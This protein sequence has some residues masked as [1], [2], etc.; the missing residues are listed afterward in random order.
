MNHPTTYETYVKEKENTLGD[1]FWSVDPSVFFDRDR[2]IEFF[3]TK[4][5]STVEKLN[6]ISRFLVYL[7]ILLFIVKRNYNIFF[8]PIIGLFVIYI[9]YYND[10]SF[11]RYNVEQF[12]QKIK[13]ALGVHPEV[14]LKIDDVG[15]ICQRPT[16]DNPFMNVL[17]S[18][19]ANN[20]TRPPACSQGDDD[21]KAET[22]KFFD[23]NLY[24]DV[25]DVWETRNN[26]RQFVTMPWTTIPNDRDSFM[27]WCWKSTNVCKD[28]DQDYCLQFEDLRVPGYS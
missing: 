27:K 23:Y 16:V 3:P 12:D 17:I 25:E 26:Q 6:A 1:L 20:A 10:S 11:H 15:N 13:T 4:D 14:P 21:V 9:I 24:K 22:K 18:D 8:I 28:G 7:S 5:M 19:Y 2:A